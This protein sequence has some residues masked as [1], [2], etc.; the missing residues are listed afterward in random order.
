[1][2]GELDTEM[3]DLAVELI[4]EFGK[5]VTLVRTEQHYVESEDEVVGNDTEHEIIVTPP[6]DF[7][8]SR[9]DGTLIQSGDTV[10]DAAVQGAPVE[11]RSSDTIRMDGDVWSIVQLG[12]I[13]SG[14]RYALYRLHLRR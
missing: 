11:P 6:Q 12:R 8:T 5:T 14:E 3:R 10:V 13:A 9:I 7:T 1:M 2:T 4:N